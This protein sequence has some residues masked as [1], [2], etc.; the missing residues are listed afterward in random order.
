M[1]TSGELPS[2]SWDRINRRKVEA[3]G[4]KLYEAEEVFEDPNAVYGHGN[5]KGR[6]IKNVKRYTVIGQT[7]GGRLLKVIFEVFDEI[8]VVTAYDAGKRDS[9]IYYR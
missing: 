4:V 6:K 1:F 9:S 2:F 8:R 5:R 7:E 3:H